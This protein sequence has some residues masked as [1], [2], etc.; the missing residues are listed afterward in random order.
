[1]DVGDRGLGH[2]F[3]F[4]RRLR[5]VATPTHQNL[6]LQILVPSFKSSISSQSNFE[7]LD[8]YRVSTPIGSLVRADTPSSAQSGF[9]SSSVN[10][11]D[12]SLLPQ[13]IPFSKGIYLWEIE[14]LNL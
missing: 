12:G 9:K 5:K 13:K 4:H 6:L 3:F 1:M 7:G 11:S 14:D 2:N 10:H 8:P